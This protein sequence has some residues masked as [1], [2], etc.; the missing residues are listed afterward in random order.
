[1]TSQELLAIERINPNSVG[2]AFALQ[3]K[4]AGHLLDK[5]DSRVR[6]YLIVIRCLWPDLAKC[7]VDLVVL[8]KSVE[9]L[10]N[11]GWRLYLQEDHSA[12]VSQYIRRH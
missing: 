10:R 1:M 7:P 4:L 8:K 6:D 9:F 12:R 11:R 2:Q 5:D 3:T